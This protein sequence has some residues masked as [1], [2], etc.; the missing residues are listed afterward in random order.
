ME[1]LPSQTDM[2]RPFWDRTVSRWT[3]PS[4]CKTLLPA[5]CLRLIGGRS[6]RCRSRLCLTRPRTITPA[7]RRRCAPQI[8][9]RRTMAKGQLGMCLRLDRSAQFLSWTR[10]RHVVAA[11]RLVLRT[12]GVCTLAPRRSIATHLWCRR[13][14]TPSSQFEWR[15]VLSSWISRTR[16][17]RQCHRLWCRCPL[18]RREPLLER[19]L[20]ILSTR[21]LKLRASRGWCRLFRLQ[22]SRNSF[23]SYPNYYVSF[24]H[25]PKKRPTVHG[26][27]W[28]RSPFGA[29]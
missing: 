7:L 13:H 27:W 5:S 3:T 23:R 12:P 8:F 28:A 25:R 22:L 10:A 21:P 2:R 14:L 19:T 18:W 4:L 1:L 24:W 17:A 26:Q 16:L 29:L 9:P 6:R 11:E 20:P 15:A